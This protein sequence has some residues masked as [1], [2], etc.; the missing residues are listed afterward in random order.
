MIDEAIESRSEISNE[1][2]NSDFNEENLDKFEV[3]FEDPKKNKALHGKF[4][5]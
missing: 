2:E 5:S 3:P 1:K 4:V